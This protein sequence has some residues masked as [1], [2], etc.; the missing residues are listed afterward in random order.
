MKG[1][2]PRSRMK[3]SK[4]EKQKWHLF[5]S[6]RTI[7]FFVF[8]I[9]TIVI[10]YDYIRELTTL[11]F[12][13]ELY[14]HIIL[15]PFVSGYFIYLKRREIFSDVKYSFTSGI[16]IILIGIV[17][18]S[19]GLNQKISLTQNDSLSLIVFSAVTFW[20]GGFVFFYG[21]GSFR[22]ATFPLLFLFFLAPIP[23]VAVEK[24]I[25]LL[26]MGSAEAAYGFFKLTGVRVLREGFTFHLPGISIEVAKQCSG[27]RSSIALF[28]TSIIA[29]QLFLQAGWKK[30][31]LAMSIFPITIFKNGLRIVTLSLLSIYVDR[32][33]L[34]SEL[35]QS[36]GILFF[37]V[38]LALLA[39]C[40]W[41]LRKSENRIK[42]SGL[43]T[44]KEVRG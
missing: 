14:S 5:M 19:I 42:S 37:V 2:H 16:M 34:F 31:V 28:I 8:N 43:G 40:L 30:I 17:L 21:L 24:I 1:K 41:V 10:F 13:N 6:S 9:V 25:L 27:I 23:D 3:S 33:I 11:S 18:Y 4:E 12:Q 15:I 29:G 39:P 20:I 36:G 35:H 44:E 22:I 26:Q 38:A 32:R 7:L